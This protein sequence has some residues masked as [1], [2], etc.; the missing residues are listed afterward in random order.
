MLLGL[1]SDPTEQLSTLKTTMVSCFTHTHSHRRHICIQT[2]A[3]AL[4]QIETETIHSSFSLCA[5]VIGF[6]QIEYNVDEDGRTVELFVTVLEGAI[7]PGVTRTV[8]LTTNQG[9]AQGRN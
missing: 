6:S 5:V 7:P 2:H 3:H 4:Y 8:M 1:L 9:T